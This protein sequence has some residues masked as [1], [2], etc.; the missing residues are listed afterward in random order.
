MCLAN[1]GAALDPQHDSGTEKKLFGAF[2]KVP[3]RIPVSGSWSCAM[4]SLGFGASHYHLWGLHADQLQAMSW[5]CK[6]L[7]SDRFASIFGI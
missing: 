4:T 1:L 3:C 2:Q 5:K 6:S 7:S